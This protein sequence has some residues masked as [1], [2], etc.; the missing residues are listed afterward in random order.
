MSTNGH[1]AMHRSRINRRAFLRGTGGIAVALP[2]LES[3]SERSAWAQD[4]KP[5]FSFFIVAANGVVQNRFWPSERGPLTE[6]TMQGKGVAPLAPYASDLLMVKGIKWPGGSPGNCGHAQ[7]Y[8]QAITGVAPGS[9]GNSSTSGGPSADMV[10][11]KAV[12]PMGTDPLTLYAGS[13][14]GAYIAERISFT[15]G[16]TPAR[17]AQLN[18]YETYKKLMGL[19]PAGSGGGSGSGPTGPSVADEM[20]VRRHSVNDVVMDDFAGLLAKANAEDKRRLDN[21]L[22]GIRQF[23]QSLMVVGENAN[24]VNEGSPETAVNYCADDGYDKTG[25]DA[26]KNGVQFN[27]NGHMIEDLVKLH[28]E[29]VALAFACNLNRTATLQWGDGT[30]GTIYKTTATG[31]YNTFH[32]IS[33]RTNSDATAGNDKWAEDAHAEIDVIR[34]GTLAHVIGAFK[35]RGLFDHSFIYWTNSIADGPSHGFNPSPVIIAGNAGGFFQ[36][37]AY[38][39]VGTKNNSLILASA[40]TAAGAPTENFGAGGGQL[41]EIHA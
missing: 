29:M 34:M 2:F 20:L 32:K 1:K 25:L 33:H 40:I 21:H 39:D 8:V 38:V 36:Q 10:I 4:E 19:S 18:P 13:Q 35:A 7:G 6:A 27:T 23:E 31:A 22:T 41:V 11:S 30:D 16:Q 12:N 9:G 26:F 37:G 3:V 5:I 15:G 28:G 24:E 14:R 17:S